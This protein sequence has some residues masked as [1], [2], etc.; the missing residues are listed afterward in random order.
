MYHVHNHP[1]ALGANL[2]HVPTP[3]SV[4]YYTYLVEQ[5]GA[6]ATVYNNDG[7]VALAAT[8]DHDVAINWALANLTAGRTEMEGVKLLGEFTIDHPLEVYS[9]TVFDLT[10]AH[11][12]L[13]N[14]SDCNMIENEDQTNGN[15]VISIIGGI[16][17]GNKA[18]QANGDG[19]N[20]SAVSYFTIREL[21][22]VDVH[23]VGIN[24]YRSN[25]NRSD[26][27]L[28]TGC[29]ILTCDTGIRDQYN[30][31]NRVLGNLVK[32]SSSIGYRIN[33]AY[34][35]IYAN[36]EYDGSNAVTSIAWRLDGA[37][38]CQFIANH[39]SV[40]ATAIRLELGGRSV[41]TGWQINT[42]GE[43][44]IDQKVTNDGCVFVGN[45][46]SD[47]AYDDAGATYDTMHL[48]GD[49]NVV[50]G[51]RI[52]GLVNWRARNHIYIAG[53]GNVVTGNFATGAA[54]DGIEINGGN[55]NIISNNRI[56]GNLGFGINIDNDADFN[57][58]ENNY[59]SGNT[60]GCANVANANCNN[61]VFTNNQFDEG[62]IADAGT[63][64]R[65]WL[66]YDPSANAFI[67]TIN[68]PVV[69]GG[70]GGFL[71]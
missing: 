42:T 57:S 5:V 2:H 19:V 28:V 33:Y 29:V 7:T 20:F 13:T 36:N 50:V 21:R 68:P 69:V 44:A 9:Y 66:N 41:F 24:F 8:P 65:A 43:H 56:L 18:N 32:D 64:T 46:F 23:D 54:N 40:C 12:F 17:D 49:E 52:Y 34:F 55:S 3:N 6:N 38:E 51:N 37:V 45:L 4:C 25:G 48:L 39:V 62:D 22:V 14:G 67:T 1:A 27:N 30:F 10:Q 31:R 11:V 60:S 71:P 15:T 35:S 59:T 63:N 26:Y 16:L 47:C 58:I 53:D 61:N 70:G